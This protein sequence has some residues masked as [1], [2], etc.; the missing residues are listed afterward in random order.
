MVLHGGG[1]PIGVTKNDA[2]IVNQ[3]D[4]VSGPF[5]ELSAGCVEGLFGSPNIQQELKGPG[6]AKEILLETV[7]KVGAE[8]IVGIQGS[9]KDGK[10]DHCKIQEQE[11][12]P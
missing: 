2:A 11:P 9:N 6:G 3:G 1:I 12:Q 7:H 5:F 4:P 10:N 8:L